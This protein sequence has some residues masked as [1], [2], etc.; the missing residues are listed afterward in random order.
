M[1]KEVVK[2]VVHFDCVS[3]E[4]PIFAIRCSYPT[5]KIDENKSQKIYEAASG[6][7]FQASVKVT[8]VPL[9]VDLFSVKP[10]SSKEFGTILKM[11]K[12]AVTLRK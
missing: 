1:F 2:T 9:Q 8:G 12:L 4:T 10:N 11:R 6:D 5:L 3:P 7:D